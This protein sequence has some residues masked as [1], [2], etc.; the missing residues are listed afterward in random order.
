MTVLL[1]DAILPNLVQTLENNPAFVHGGPFA[2]I[3]HGCNSVMATNTALKLADYVV[4]EAGFGADLGA[5]KFFDIKCRKAG[6]DA[7]GRRDGGDGAGAQVPWRRQARGISARR[8]SPRWRRASPISAAIST[9]SRIRH[10]AGGRHQPLRHRHRGRARG[11]PQFCA[12]GASRPC[13]QPLGRRRQ[14]RRAAGALVAEQAE[15][16]EARFK[17]LYAD[18][19][20]LCEKIRTIARTSMAPRTCDRR[21]RRGALAAFEKEGFGKFPICM[22]KTQYSFST[23]PRICAARPKATRCRCARCGS[24]PAR[25][26]S[27]RSPATS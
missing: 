1:R 26:S 22:A 20:P 4:T 7:V 11:D 2:N 13:V 15:P 23:N 10:S 5:E 27:W 14:G 17:P 25:A 6:P 24:P 16:G 8:T 3:A 21:P 19:M 18:E 12:A 9:T